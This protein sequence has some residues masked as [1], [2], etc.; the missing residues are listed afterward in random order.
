MTPDMIDE[1]LADAR[2]RMLKSVEA[3]RNEFGSSLALGWKMRRRGELRSP[4]LPDV[5]SSHCW[6]LPEFSMHRLP[7]PCD[8]VTA[9]GMTRSSPFRVASA[10][11]CA[12]IEMLLAPMN[13][14][15][16]VATVRRG[17][18]TRT[19]WNALSIEMQVSEFA[20]SGSRL[21]ACGSLQ[22]IQ[23]DDAMPMFE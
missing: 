7:V 23:A 17:S 1:L 13:R 12:E 22:L 6:L 18:C 11:A 5:R 14:P 4:K 20:T 19:L 10:T 16:K 9:A 21:R 15:K 2:E 3:M 8:A